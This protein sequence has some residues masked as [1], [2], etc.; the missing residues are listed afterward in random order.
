M[1]IILSILIIV[2][3]L[4]GIYVNYT[5]YKRNKEDTKLLSE[6]REAVSKINEKENACKDGICQISKKE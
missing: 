6:M 5:T 3:L 4:T 1:D 2:F